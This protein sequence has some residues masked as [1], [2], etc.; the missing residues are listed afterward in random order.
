MLDDQL[1]TVKLVYFDT[2]AQS[3]RLIDHTYPAMP[4][5]PL[6]GTS[7]VYLAAVFRCKD[8]PRG[9][10]KDGMTLEELE[11]KGMFV[12]WLEKI[13][14]NV[15]EEMAMFGEGY[16]YREVDGTKWYKETDRGY[17]QINSKIYDRCDNARICLP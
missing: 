12:G 2:E 13:D 1:A 3:I 4:K 16:A 15:S 6:K 11:K 5:S 8:C 9:M 7:D 10:L 14:P 17:D